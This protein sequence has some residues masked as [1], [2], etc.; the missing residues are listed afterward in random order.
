[1]QPDVDRW[2]AAIEICAN[3]AAQVGVDPAVPV[4]RALMRPDLRPDGAMVP[5]QISVF[6]P[7]LALAGILK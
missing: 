6:A 1:R 5:P 3:A 4:V 2:T 7:T